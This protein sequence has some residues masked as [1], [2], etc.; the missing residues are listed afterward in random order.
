MESQNAL[1]QS[2]DQRVLVIDD[3]LENALTAAEAI[4]RSGF[5]PVVAPSV[6]T[7]LP[8]VADSR[9]VMTDG[10]LPIHGKREISEADMEK[11]ARLH[12]PSIAG[13]IRDTIVALFE[14]EPDSSVF[15]SYGKIRS[16]Q[17]M[18]LS[19]SLP[20]KEDH[21][22]ASMFKG[23]FGKLQSYYSQAMPP[24]L[25]KE[26]TLEETTRE[27][28]EKNTVLMKEAMALLGRDHSD[29]ALSNAMRFFMCGSGAPFFYKIV[30]E[31]RRKNVPVGILSSIDHGESCVG[32]IAIMNLATMDQLKAC[33]TNHNKSSH[34]YE[35][36]NTA[37]LVRRPEK[38]VEDWEV[39]LKR[40]QSVFPR[41]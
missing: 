41:L 35:I 6:Q 15:H 11:I 18:W 36:S 34:R 33:L 24:A 19:M 8:L 16:E 14:S 28:A 22:Y 20:E 37:V 5:I 23:L 30:E 25:A 9:L 38:T 27:D 17:D 4:K 21:F 10:Y 29:D 7:A 40:L 39:L 2:A 12:L 1:A 32:M 13:P 31:A 3:M 26:F